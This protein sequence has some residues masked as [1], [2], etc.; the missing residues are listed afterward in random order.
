MSLARVAILLSGRGSN[1]LAL[2]QAIAEGR[3]P[4]RIVAVISDK[5]AAPGLAKARD[6][7]LRAEV[8]SRKGH[9]SRE[10]HEASI[11]ARA[12]RSR[13]RMGFAWRAS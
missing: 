5:K 2:H 10:E 7:G 1:F 12:R 13:R 9:R 4:A 6:L 11:L 8:C 3:I